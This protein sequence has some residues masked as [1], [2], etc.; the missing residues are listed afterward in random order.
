LGLV[1]LVARA[2]G[3]R[4]H[5]PSGVGGARRSQAVFLTYQ[6]QCAAVIGILSQRPWVVECR[7]ISYS[8]ATRHAP[9]ASVVHI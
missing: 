7:A 8:T 3:R 6:R 5:A 9:A 4:V 1:A 2:F